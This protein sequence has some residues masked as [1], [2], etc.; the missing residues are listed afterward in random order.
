[1]AQPG[2]PHILFERRLPPS[3]LRPGT[4]YAESRSIKQLP[5]T[6]LAVL[7]RLDSSGGVEMA[8][9]SPPELEL[10]PLT[11]D[12]DCFRDHREHE[13]LVNALTT[14]DDLKFDPGLRSY[15]SDIVQEAHATTRIQIVKWDQENLLEEK[16]D[17]K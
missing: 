12:A 10:E 1:M 7:S 17:A 16:K 2:D 11:V 8:A 5:N 9:E 15:F 14:K 3:L 6:N 4:A 13:Y